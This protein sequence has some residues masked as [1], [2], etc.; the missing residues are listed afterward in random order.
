MI[1][2]KVF[3]PRRSEDSPFTKK[4]IKMVSFIPNF[5]SITKKGLQEKVDVLFDELI[6]MDGGG[7][8]VEA[9][10]IYI[11]RSKNKEIEV[12]TRIP[13]GEDYSSSK[14]ITEP[15]LASRHGTN[16]FISAKYFSER[17]IS[18]SRR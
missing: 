12:P 16:Y 10:K 11:S 1:T 17:Q 6:R 14:I 3:D 2:T 15:I 8:V 4:Y 18:F 13:S 5:M 7:L 9:P